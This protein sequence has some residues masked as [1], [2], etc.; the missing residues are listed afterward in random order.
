MAWKTWVIKLRSPV[1]GEKLITYFFEPT[2]PVNKLIIH[3][4]ES[5]VTNA[6]V[7][8]GW[9]F[10]DAKYVGEFDKPIEGV[11]KGKELARE[12]GW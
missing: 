3:T 2:H 5:W 7:K 12:L 9:E 11:R 10:V 6:Y 4:L 8:R 1:T